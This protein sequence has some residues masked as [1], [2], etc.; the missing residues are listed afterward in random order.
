MKP[1]ALTITLQN[2]YILLVKRQDVQQWV[3]PGGGIEPGETPEEAAV[4][5]TFEE[6]ALRVKVIQKALFLKSQSRLASDTTLFFT[7]PLDSER[8]CVG[9]QKPLPPNPTLQ[10]EECC[11]IDYFPLKDLPKQF[12]FLH[13]QWL[14]EVLSNNSLTTGC[15]ERPL[16]E[17]T[18]PRAVL[19][20]LQHP[21]SAAKYLLT[22]KIK[23]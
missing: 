6:T 16:H 19:Y 11:E 12:F 10:N 20:F 7:E 15:I 14:E 21:I 23:R 4:R 8:P 5:E 1:A 17:V 18:I 2:D 22:R 3:L 13:R 9:A